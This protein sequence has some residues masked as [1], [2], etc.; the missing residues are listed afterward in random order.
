MLGDLIKWCYGWVLGGDFPFWVLVT[1]KKLESSQTKKTK[2]NKWSKNCC[3]GLQQKKK[4]E[5]KTRETKVLADL[6]QWGHKGRQV[7]RKCV[8]QVVACHGGRGW[9][10]FTL[11]LPFT[12]DDWAQGNA[13]P[14][15]ARCHDGTGWVGFTLDLPFTNDDW[16]QGKVS[17]KWQRAMMARDGVGFT[18]D[19]PFDVNKNWI[20]DLG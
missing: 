4:K 3:H 11:D 2:R 9:V 16:A 6:H 17:L 8:P 7:A 13:I 10:G 15:M 5:K 18:L 1:E 20:L 12:N 19:L 14:Q